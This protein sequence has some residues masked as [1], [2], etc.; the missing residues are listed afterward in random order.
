MDSE[1]LAGCSRTRQHRILFAMPAPLAS[2]IDSAVVAE[3]LGGNEFA[4]GELLRR[5][6]RLVMELISRIV[7]DRDVAAD[8]AQE[9]FVRAFAGLEA[10]RAEGPFSRW[11]LRI[12][13]NGAVDYLRKKGLDTVSIERGPQAVRDRVMENAISTGDSTPTSQTSLRKRKPRAERAD[14]E[15]AISQLRPEQR[16]CFLLR[17]EEELSYDSIAR[18]MGIPVGTA[19]TH[20]YRARARLRA[21]LEEM[22]KRK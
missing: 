14:V 12:A 15:L 17:H 3:A 22:Q 10:Y 11:I 6:L 7:G 13:N 8:L 1:R 5:H 2:L 21:A 9:A 18:H 4:H 19:K 16:R 20:V